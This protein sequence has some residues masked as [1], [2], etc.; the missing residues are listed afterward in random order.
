[1]KILKLN[2]NKSKSLESSHRRRRHE[3]FNKHF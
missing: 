1:M 3:K 2:Y